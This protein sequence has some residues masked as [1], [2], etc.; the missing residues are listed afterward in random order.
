[1]ERKKLEESLGK[2]RILLLE[3]EITEEKAELLRAW[4]Q[5]LN[6]QSDEEIKL[7]INS[8]GGEVAPALLVYD[9]IS[10]SNASVIGIVNGECSSVAIVILQATKKRLATRHSFF[11]LHSI[12]IDFGKIV[13]DENIDKK[14]REVLERGKKR[15]ELIR[16]ILARRTSKSLQEIE[17]LEK[18]GKMITAERAKELGLV[19]EIVD[20]EYKT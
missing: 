16:Q 14:I 11:F 19:D 3:G 6:L 1:M 4:L 13:F 2:K 18:E 15:Q 8:K 20:G 7:I 5:F 12:S 10:L 9:A 17:S